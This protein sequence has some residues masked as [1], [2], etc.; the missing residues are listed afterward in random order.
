MAEKNPAAGAD[1]K[2][3]SD[4]DKDRKGILLLLLLLFLGLLVII[5]L[6]AFNQG[7]GPT[8]AL[9]A[10]GGSPNIT[11]LTN[12]TPRSWLLVEDTDLNLTPPAIVP[13]GVEIPQ[14]IRHLNVSYDPFRRKKHHDDDDD[15]E[16][17]IY[18]A[19]ST[20]MYVDGKHQDSQMGFYRVI[21]ENSD[22]PKYITSIETLFIDGKDYPMITFDSD[23]E[24]GTYVIQFKEGL[25]GSWED[26]ATIPNYVYTTGDCTDEACYEGNTYEFIGE[27]DKWGSM[28]Q[29]TGGSCESIVC[30]YEAPSELIYIDT[31]RQDLRM[32]AYSIFYPTTSEKKSASIDTIT[33]DNEKAIKLEFNSAEED[34]YVVLFK[35]SLVGPWDEIATIPHYVYTTGDC[36][37]E[38]CYE[39]NTYEFHG[40]GYKN[41]TM[42]AAN[43]D[44]CKS[45]ISAY[46]EPSKPSRRRSSSNNNNAVSNT[47]SNTPSNT[48][49][50]TNTVHNNV[51]TNSL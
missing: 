5:T 14:I 24:A 39:Y 17:C 41:S 45:K 30:I 16:V 51:V 32:G 9:V 47:N 38:A 25:T 1:S 6:W 43:E 29:V 27:D 35:E 28:E 23:K 49:S 8:G 33:V 19:P 18:E 31:D 37:E 42:G 13:V 40:A 2:K 10:V 48:P 15:N 20:I 44:A 46:V 34:Y 21:Y 22:Q 36:A 7:A 50:N 3:G 12:L 26:I 4:E 11:N